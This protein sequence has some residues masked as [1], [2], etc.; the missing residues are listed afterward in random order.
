MRGALAV[1]EQIG[2]GVQGASAGVERV[3][4]AAAVPTC[5]Q[6]HPAAALIEG[7]ASQAHHVERVHH[8]RRLGQFLGGSG[9][10]PGE[11]IHSN[12][13]HAVTPVLRPLGQPVL[14]RLF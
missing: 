1:G 7:V 5:R 9:L 8:R 12:N 13:V 3:G 2:T 14:K 11:A 4:L 6:L 10:E